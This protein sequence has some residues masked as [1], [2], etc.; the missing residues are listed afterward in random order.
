[1]GKVSV[2]W[3]DSQLMVGA[4]SF[5]HPLVIGSWPEKSP[6]WAGMKASDLLLI[7]AAACTAYD[8]VMI[9]RKQKKNLEKF[10]VEVQGDQLPDPPY[11]F[12]KIHVHYL[13]E[14]DLDDRSI[15]RAIQL[16]EDKYCSV[17]NTLREGVSIS[18]SYVIH[19]ADVKESV[20]AD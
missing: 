9:L 14:G 17:L 16:S 12:T 15:Q 4:D 13:F 8:V 7:S 20:A 10:E 5:G 11:R 18:S 6:E 1:M 2:K 3:V 19:P